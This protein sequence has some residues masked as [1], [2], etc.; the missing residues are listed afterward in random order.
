M[1]LWKRMKS[2]LRI[3]ELDSLDLVEQAMK[4]EERMLDERDSLAGGVVFDIFLSATALVCLVL[5]ARY[6][7][8]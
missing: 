6:L 5:F 2:T 4:E 7:W 8:R 3:R 1:S